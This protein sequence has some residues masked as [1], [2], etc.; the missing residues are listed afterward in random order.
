MADGF[1]ISNKFID[2]LPDLLV[3]A[4]NAYESKEN[5]YVASSS[6]ST[7]SIISLLVAVGA[8]YLSWHRNEKET[9]FKRVSYAIAAAI[10]G[11][12]YL[13]YYYFTRNKPENLSKPTRG[14]RPSR[15]M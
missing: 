15:G 9:K 14:D 4:Q 10:F 2:S 7:S 5:F 3:K 1:L 11:Y 12:M 13:I 6:R 8:G